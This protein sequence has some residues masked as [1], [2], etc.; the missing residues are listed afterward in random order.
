[1]QLVLGVHLGN[2]KRVRNNVGALIEKT[3][4]SPEDKQKIRDIVDE[5]IRNRTEIFPTLQNLTIELATA[6]FQTRFN[7]TLFIKSQ[8]TIAGILLELDPD[9]D[10]DARTLGGATGLV[11][12]EFPKHMPNTIW[13]PAW[14]SHNYQS[15][16]SNEDIRDI[17]TQRVGRAFKG[18]G[19]GMARADGC[20]LK[21]TAASIF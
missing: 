3:P 10:Q 4:E 5:V 1:M 8:I 16:L 20:L 9:F 17:W 6:G 14:N 13:F 19:S 21:R 12:R 18:L 7:I 2:T 15:M 11:W